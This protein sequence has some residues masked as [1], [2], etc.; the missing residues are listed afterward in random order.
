MIDA[1]WA[2]SEQSLGSSNARFRRQSGTTAFG[3]F[4]PKAD[5]DYRL[6]T[7][8]VADWNALEVG[9]HNYIR[10]YNHWQIKLGLLK[11]S[12]MESRLRNTA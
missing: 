11:L 9:V 2:Q 5:I 12:Q 8:L 6:S 4:R 10:H 3:S 7:L 1:I